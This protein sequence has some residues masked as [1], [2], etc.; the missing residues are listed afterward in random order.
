M[1]LVTKADYLSDKVSEKLFWQKFHNDWII[2]VSNMTKFQPLQ[3][4]HK[5]YL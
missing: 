5:L 1:F 4:I 3:E 2:Q